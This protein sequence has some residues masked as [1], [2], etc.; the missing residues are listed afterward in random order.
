MISINSFINLALFS[1]ISLLEILRFKILNSSSFEVK[2]W[3]S[4][5]DAAFEEINIKIVTEDTTTKRTICII[6]WLFDNILKSLEYHVVIKKKP[7]KIEYIKTIIFKDGRMPKVDDFELSFAPI[8]IKVET[9]QFN[10]DKII[11]QLIVIQK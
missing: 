1:L 5:T 9:N 10:P 7:L 11:N 6:R 2:F 4:F 8:K 3:F